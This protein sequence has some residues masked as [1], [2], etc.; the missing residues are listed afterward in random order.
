MFDYTLNEIKKE[1]KTKS[2]EELLEYCLLIAKYKKD[3]K[4][5]LGYL[6][7]DDED[8]HTY[9]QRVLA[10]IE[11]QFEE[12]QDQ[13]HWYLIKK[14]WR[15]ILRNIS[16]CAKFAKN[17]ELEI[18]MTI[19]FVRQVQASGVPYYAFNTLANIVA[20]QLKKIRTIL[21]QLHEDLQFDYERE[22]QSLL[23]RE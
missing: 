12:I 10:H 17:K 13:K 11:F 22:L 4:E 1:L 7:F 18:Q 9:L 16:K 5:Y 14:S 3:N 8:S 15:K 19:H 21:P 23:E 6:M 2:N 20:L